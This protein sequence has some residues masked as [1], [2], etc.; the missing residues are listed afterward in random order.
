MQIAR[1][2]ASWVFDHPDCAVYLPKSSQV[3]FALK[4]AKTIQ[5]H[6]PIWHGVYWDVRCIA[7]CWATCCNPRF[8]SNWPPTTPTVVPGQVALQSFKVGQCLN[9][10]RTNVLKF[11]PYI[12]VYYV[13]VPKTQIRLVDPPAPASMSSSRFTADK[14]YIATSRHN[15]W[16][17]IDGINR[18]IRVTFVFVCLCLYYSGVFCVLFW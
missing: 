7:T 6:R 11:I 2:D 17:I 14:P 4:H 10:Q 3:Y 15:C 5:K 8:H 9:K 1:S 13:C 18:Y 12:S 16:N